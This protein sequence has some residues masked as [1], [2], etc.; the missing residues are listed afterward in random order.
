MPRIFPQAAANSLIAKRWWAIGLHALCWAAGW[1]GLSAIALGNDEDQRFVAGLRERRLFALAEAYCQEQLANPQLPELERVQLTVDL[2][3]VYAEHALNSRG[4]ARTE[5]WEQARRIA[6]DYERRSPPPRLVL[7]QVQDALTVLARGELARMESEVSTNG[8]AAQAEAREMLRESSLMLTKIERELTESIPTRRLNPLRPEELSIEELQ[9]LLHNVQLQL[10]R[11]FRNQ[12]LCY[13]PGSNDRTA[14]LTE[15]LDRLQSPL[16]ELARNHPL[17]VELRLEQIRGTR[18]LGD[19]EIA[20]RYLE[21]LAQD[22]L[23]PQ[24]QLSVRAESIRLHLATQQFDAALAVIAQG[25]SVVGVTAAELDF[26]FLETYVELWK[27]GA[28]QK[29]QELAARWRDKSLATAAF[30]EQ[31]HG[32]YWARIAEMLLVR[33]GAG[34]GDGS[35]EILRRS[36]DDLYRKG[37][38]DD[39]VSAYDKAAEAAEQANDPTQR[40]ELAYKAALVRQQQIKHAESSERFHKLSM[41]QP[42]HPSASNAHL[43]AI[44]N[45]RQSASLTGKWPAQYSEWLQ[46]HLARWPDPSTADTAALWLGEF[47]AGRRAWRVASEAYARVR[48]DSPHYDAAV[49]ASGACWLRRL[50]ELRAAQMPVDEEARQAATFLEQLVLG[51]G[52]Q[53]PTDWTP[54]LRACATNLATVRLW[55]LGEA[56]VET[57]HLLRVALQGEPPPDDEWRS[58][59]TALLIL[60]L[61]RQPNRLADARE[62]LE[63]W[64]EASSGQLLGLMQ[65]LEELS[66]SLSH[67]A[68]RDVAALRIDL[69][70]RL[71]RQTADLEPLQL[72]RVQRGHAEALVIAGELARAIEICERLAKAWP[73]DAAVRELYARLLLAGTDPDSWRQGL[74]QWRQIAARSRPRTSRWFLAKYSVALAQYKLGSKP[75]AAKLIRYL[76]ATEDLDAS[77]LKREFDELLGMCLE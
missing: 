50:E 27:R 25:R 36:A 51:E 4:E 68:R 17:A 45:L 38:L 48:P 20:Q 42:T 41:A 63:Q 52:Q 49:L 53:T 22:D 67:E 23:E 32:V 33:V 29:N 46:E 3:R 14:L 75:E 72:L 64:T 15:G 66:P 26:A 24:A 44:A 55:F 69:A 16:L 65:Q 59:A 5:L 70:T 30:I 8:D 62:E 7:V 61:A 76:Q 54:T 2:I 58:T 47:E 57:E 71:E 73:N 9:S 43:L 21:S 6:A 31:T 11:A 56:S 13:P 40:F 35:V 37:S 18:L 10:V 34:S 39:A 1:I 19:T 60:A 28:D 77:G 12:A 74:D